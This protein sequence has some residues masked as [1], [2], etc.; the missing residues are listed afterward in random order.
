M[1]RL[2]VVKE[3]GGY[4]PVFEGC[5]DYDLWLRIIAVADIINLSDMLLH[6][7]M[8]DNQVSW[9]RIEQRIFSEFAVT[10]FAIDRHLE[11]RVD[12][13]R[14]TA[15]DWETLLTIGFK[16]TEIKDCPANSHHWRRGE[17]D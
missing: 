9:K 11:Q 7:R 17:C 3:V 10:R 13:G 2:E 14:I 5:E 8:H 16:P 6:Y 15:I 12:L 1:A 4:R